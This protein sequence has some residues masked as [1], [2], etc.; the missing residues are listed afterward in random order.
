MSGLRARGNLQVDIE[1]KDGNVAS[2]RIASTERRSVK[3]RIG[4]ETRSVE[5]ERM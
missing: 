2:Y 1:W 4:G 3:V 5:A